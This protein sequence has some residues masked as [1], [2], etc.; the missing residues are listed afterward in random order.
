MIDR[1]ERTDVMFIHEKHP[2]EGKGSDGILGFRRLGW[3]PA[4]RDAT[5]RHM[6]P[7]DGME[8]WSDTCFP[9]SEESP[10]ATLPVVAHTGMLSIGEHLHVPAAAQG[11]IQ[12]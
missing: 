7:C 12:L 1:V 10:C 2:Q 4:A 6:A 9:S 8:L 3:R 11:N 5:G